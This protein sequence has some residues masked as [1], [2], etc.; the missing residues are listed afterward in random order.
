MDD[1]LLY[2]A[3]KEFVGREEIMGVVKGYVPWLGWMVILLQT[4]PQIMQ[5]GG[6]LLLGI[7]LLT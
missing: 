5:L 7:A 6:T 4:Y 3:D 2:P 1:T